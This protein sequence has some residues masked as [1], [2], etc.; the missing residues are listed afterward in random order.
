MSLIRVLWWALSGLSELYT[1]GEPEPYNPDTR[2]QQT[3]SRKSRE[4]SSQ[5]MQR[6][7][8]LPLYRLI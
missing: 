2:Q 7:L 8:R 3:A 1:T 5:C 4:E 6:A